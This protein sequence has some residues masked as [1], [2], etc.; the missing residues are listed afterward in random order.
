MKKFIY[1]RGQPA[2]GKITVA[3]ILES[4]LGYKVFWF[5][6]LK[7]VVFDIVK[8]HRIPRLMDELTVP[9]IKYLVD[10]GDNLI[11]VRPSPEEETVQSVLVAVGDNND[12]DI[13]VVRLNASYKELLRRVEGR[14]D[15]YR[16]SNKEDLDEYVNSR[17]VVDISGEIVIDT[18]GLS[19]E[20]V[21]DEII[22][23][24]GLEQLAVTNN[25]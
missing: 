15:P 22:K 3:R 21:A 11:Y 18:D 5:H 13:S 8:E 19:P 4:K 9:I 17:S 24:L 14:D 7:N 6:D 10:R 23:L 1:L 2:T 16:I 20:Q 12:Y 25:D